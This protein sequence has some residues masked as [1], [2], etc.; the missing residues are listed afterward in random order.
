ME[1]LKIFTLN[2]TIEKA[3]RKPLIIEKKVFSDNYPTPKVRSFMV[4]KICLALDLKA[5]LDTGKHFERNKRLFEMNKHTILHDS[6]KIPIVQSVM[7][8]KICQALNLKAQPESSN[9]RLNAA[10]IVYSEMI[11]KMCLALGI[12]ANLVSSH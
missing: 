4:W 6:T 5:D 2:K 3:N 7:V 9:D 11:W 10:P 12:E 1:L 8:L